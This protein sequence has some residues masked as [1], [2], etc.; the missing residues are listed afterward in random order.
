MKGREKKNST[1]AYD[2]VSLDEALTKNV[3]CAFFESCLLIEMV[4][5]FNATEN[6]S[7]AITEISKLNKLY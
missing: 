3:Y 5:T 7:K 6:V 2:R 1:I 4:E